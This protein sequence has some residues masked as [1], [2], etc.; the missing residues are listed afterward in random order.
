MGVSYAQGEGVPQNHV[1]AYAW[2]SVAATTGLKLA[3]E[4]RDLVARSMTPSQL[5][6]GQELAASYFEQ[7]PPK[8]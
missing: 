1:Q 6:K 7:Y 3:T 2:L 4:T 5:E 8:Q